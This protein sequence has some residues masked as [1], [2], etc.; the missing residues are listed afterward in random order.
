MN[1]DTSTPSLARYAVFANV[2]GRTHLA[3]MSGD[4]QL[5]G[6]SPI[7]GTRLNVFPGVQP[8]ISVDN[9]FPRALLI[10]KNDG[11]M[12]SEFDF[13]FR[14]LAYQHGIFS[15]QSDNK[16]EFNRLEAYVLNEA[17]TV[18]VGEWLASIDREPFVPSQDLSLGNGTRN[19]SRLARA[20]TSHLPSW[21]HWLPRRKQSAIMEDI[22][23][24]PYSMP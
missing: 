14:N 12:N 13:H 6:D 17:N 22:P 9:S 8:I 11:T 23:D 19:Q 7:P 18:N 24:L 15:G 3:R 5:L 2:N 1:N 20:I 21:L 10:T 4:P 16:T